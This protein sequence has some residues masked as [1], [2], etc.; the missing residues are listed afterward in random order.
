MAV[1]KK[2][3]EY[4]IRF[5]SARRRQPLEERRIAP[6]FDLRVP[7]EYQHP[8]IVGQ[9]TTWNLS[10]SGVHIASASFPIRQGA[11]V[12]ARFWFFPGSS[13]TWFPGEVVRHT[14]DGFAVRFVDL[15]PEHL[16]ILHEALPSNGE[17]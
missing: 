6:R 8:T 1:P 11:G 4:S 10:L 3:G 5:P 9:G 7:V 12:M 16:E 14:R 15:A 13:D 2:G 17:D